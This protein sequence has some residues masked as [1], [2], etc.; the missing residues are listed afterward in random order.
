MSS[1]VYIRRVQ[2][3]GYSTLSISLPKKWAQKR[4]IG[5]GARLVIHELPDGALLLRSEHDVS[6][7]SVRWKAHLNLPD[8]TMAEVERGII[9]L[10]EAGYDVI[11]VNAPANAL[12]AVSR[13][14]R[15]LSGVEVVEEGENYVTLEAVL[16][17]SSLS[18][19]K[20]LDRMA[21]LVRLS[22][23]DFIRYA[24]DGDTLYLARVIERDDELDKFYFL[25]V[26]HSSVC[27]RKPHLL[28]ELGINDSAEVLPFLYYGK[29]LERMG[30]TLVQLAMYVRENRRDLNRDLTTTMV[31]ALDL[32]IRSFK[33]TGFEAPRRLMSIHRDFF[34]QRGSSSILADP[35]LSLVGN[36]L[37]LCLDVLDSRVELEAVK[38]PL[39]D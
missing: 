32:S 38:R 12:K 4:G 2:S 34:E 25:L 26:R 28:R 11:V 21:T 39:V 10:Y 35:L 7:P 20:I 23:E 24:G 17:H 15:R 37:S 5:K 14:W 13:L 19:G 18:F 6:A 22:L 31:E 16:D 3:V 29:T 8:G 33:G 9:A 36:F 1:R 30:D 27:F